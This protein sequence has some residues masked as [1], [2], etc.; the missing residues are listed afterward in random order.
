MSIKIVGAVLIVAGCGLFGFLYAGVHRRETQCL[1]QYISALE[2]M[3][4]ELQYRLTPLPE[5]CKMTSGVCDGCLK[6]LFMALA[7]ELETQIAPDVA[8][9]VRTVLE[10]IVDLPKL[11]RIAFTQ[12]GCI[13][14]RFDLEG[15]CKGLESLRAEATQ[16]LMRHSE[17][18]DV[19]VRS[20]QTLGICAGAAMVILFI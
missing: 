18:Q 5:L 3:E 19:R 1:R 7:Q 16:L 14:G 8:Q 6:K 17:N 9:C 13:L 10:K 15:Q 20:Y 4:W 11:T 2:F 12:L